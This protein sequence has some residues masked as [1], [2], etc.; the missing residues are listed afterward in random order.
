M[1]PWVTL[2]QSRGPSPIRTAPTVEERA[3]G[4]TGGEIAP[5]KCPG[6]LGRLRRSRRGTVRCRRWSESAGPHAQAGKFVG[7]E[8][9]GLLTAR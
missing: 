5:V 2:N 9:S 7:G 3:E 1:T 4:L 6:R 8:Y